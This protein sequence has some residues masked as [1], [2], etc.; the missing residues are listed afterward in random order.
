MAFTST[1]V[2]AGVMG[3]LKYERYTYTSTGVTSGTIVTGLPAIGH[4]SWSP[5]TIRAS[6]TY[7]D[8]STAGS[9]AFTGLTS[10]DTGELMV[11]GKK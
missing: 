10:G 11:W 5:K 3:D 4:S 1:K 7:N 9:V 2:D 6:S 8:T